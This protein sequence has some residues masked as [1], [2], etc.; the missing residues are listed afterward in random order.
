MPAQC[1]GAKKKTHERICMK[2]VVVDN[3]NSIDGI[4]IKEIESPAF[5]KAKFASGSAPR[6]SAS[7]MD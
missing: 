7:S 4:S 6:R 3:Y 1:I 2:A 5:P